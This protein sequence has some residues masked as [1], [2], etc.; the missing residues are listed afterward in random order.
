[1]STTDIFKAPEVETIPKIALS[2]REAAI[3]VGVSDRTIHQ[4]IKDGELPSMRIGTRQL[5]PT[6]VLR[7]WCRGRTRTSA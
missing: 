1:M 7:E 6:D 5:I 4:L 2:V 3:A